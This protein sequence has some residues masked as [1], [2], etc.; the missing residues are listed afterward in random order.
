MDKEAITQDRPLYLSDLKDLHVTNLAAAKKAVMEKVGYVQKT[1]TQGLNY[2]FA[3]ETELIAALRPAMIEAGLVMTP[4]MA[5]VLSDESLPT[6]SGGT[7]RRLTI[8]RQFRLTHVDTGEYETIEVL[9]EAADSGDKAAGKA[10]T[11]AKK[12]ALRDAFLIETGDDP[13]FERNE[14]DE[15]VGAQKHVHQ[16]MMQSLISSKTAEDLDQRWRKIC[17]GKDG[18][19]TRQFE[20]L[21]AKMR[22]LTEKLSVNSHA[23]T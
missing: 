19:T 9:G 14:R 7:Q 15:A 22:E 2:T 1:K 20:A 18:L 16:R 11:H 5:S 3:S 6:K 21:D 12:Y 10:M 4:I 17:S 23:K 13:D 8:L